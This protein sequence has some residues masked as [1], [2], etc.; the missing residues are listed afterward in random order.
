MNVI[1]GMYAVCYHYVECITTSTQIDIDI[2]HLD[3]LQILL[4]IK[5]KLIFV[6]HYIIL[7]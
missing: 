2:D 4:S 1:I 5:L 7:I 3:H 6:I